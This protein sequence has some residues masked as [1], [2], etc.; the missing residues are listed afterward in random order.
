ME[1]LAGNDGGLPQLFVLEVQGPG[2]KLHYNTTSHT[3]RFPV[4]GLQSNTFYQV[5]P[6]PAVQHILPGQSAACS[7]THSTRSVRRQQSNTFYLVSPRPAVQHIL[8]GQSVACSPTRSA[9]SVRGL[10]PFFEI[11]P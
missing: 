9:R 6:P 1:C 11:I 4:R 10:Q 7:P 2:G 8:P 3:P 5:S